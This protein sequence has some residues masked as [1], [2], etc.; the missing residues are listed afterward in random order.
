VRY[1]NRTEVTQNQ[2]PNSTTIPLLVEYH[3]ELTLSQCSQ[4]EGVGAR[5]SLRRKLRPTPC[6]A[7]CHASLATTSLI[8]IP[9]DTAGHPCWMETS[10][11]RY[12]QAV[13]AQSAD[14]HGKGNHERESRESNC[15]ERLLIDVLDHL[16]SQT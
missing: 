8:E 6:F 14:C 11:K 13:K 5:A 15:D 10:T 2:N 7:T 9:Y 16:S 12:K 1:T 4:P 3:Y